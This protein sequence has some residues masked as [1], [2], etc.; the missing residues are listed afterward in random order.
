MGDC[1]E[2]CAVEVGF[3]SLGNSQPR[4]FFSRGMC[5]QC[6]GWGET[7]CERGRL[8][9]YYPDLGWNGCLEEERLENVKMTSFGIVG[10]TGFLV[11]GT[12]ADRSPH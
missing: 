9:R 3:Y 8:G 11:W 1:F 10:M 7:G 4:G 2:C 12:D 6:L 5:D